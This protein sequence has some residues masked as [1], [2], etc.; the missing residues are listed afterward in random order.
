[1]KVMVR[2]FVNSTAAGLLAKRSST[3]TT[4]A[5]TFYV[6]PDFLA[7]PLD[8]KLLVLCWVWISV[9]G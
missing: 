9:G 7:L 8:V 6:S 1:M 3:R 2:Y 5:S 4:F